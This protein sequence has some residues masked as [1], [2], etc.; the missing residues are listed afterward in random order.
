MATTT[1][2]TKS[3]VD[4]MDARTRLYDSL[5]YTY[6]KKKEAS[7]ESYRKA[8]SQA[9]NSLLARGMQRSSYGQQTLANINQ[10]KIRAQG[11]IDDALIA[12]YENRL[13]QL[14]RDEKADEQWE[15]QFAENQRQ[16]DTNLAYNKERAAV[17]D[18][19]WQ[20]SFD[21]QA[22]RDTVADQ[23]YAEQMAYQKERDTVADTQW[24]KSFDYQAGRDTIA[25]QQYAE[26]MAYQ[27]ERDAVADTQYAEQFAYQKE[28]DTVSDQQWQQAFDYQ[29]ARDIIGDEQWQKT[30]DQNASQF[31][32]QLAADYAQALLNAGMEVPQSLLSQAGLS[33]VGGSVV[34][35]DSGSGGGY[36]GGGSGKSASTSSSSSSSSDS[37]SSFL[38]D[39]NQQGKTISSGWNFA[40]AIGTGVKNMKK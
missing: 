38:F 4:N 31:N 30:F 22:G 10:Q 35:N 36:Y 26:K 40:D 18:E 32:R 9:D 21:Y 3:D 29:K 14:E 27:R 11:E 20:K 6:G 2:R 1:A 25:D 8:Y 13:Y 5:S 7:D 17:A 24:Q 23:Q 16:Y 34:M 33:I 28:R 37:D 39:L 15:R 19:Q 12:D